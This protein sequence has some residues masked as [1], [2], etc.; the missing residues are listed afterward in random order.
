LLSTEQVDA[1]V[2]AAHLGDS[3]S[4]GGLAVVDVTNGSHVDMGLGS[5]VDVVA[6]CTLRLL[7]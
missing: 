7:L 2:I 4:Q 3:S 1:L 6:E 5:T